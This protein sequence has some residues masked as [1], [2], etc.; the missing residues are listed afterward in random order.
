MA[1]AVLR[2]NGYMRIIS[3]RGAKGLAAE[4]TTDSIALAATLPV[5][6]I[7][8]DIHHTRN[9]IVVAYHNFATPHKLAISELTF[10]TLKRE[11]PHIATLQDA[12]RSCGKTPALIESKAPG[13]IAKSLDIIAKHPK[14]AIASFKPEE[15]LAARIHLPEHQTFL[16]QRFRPFGIIKKAQQIDASGITINKNW[17]LLL[18]YYYWQAQRHGLAIYTYTLNSAPVAKLLAK[19]MPKLYICTDYPTRLLNP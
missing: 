8:F 6:Y 14:A 3:H 2:Y 15:I 19:F 9:N 1:R 7:E 4:N 16:L 11:V 18:P 12:L 17:L 10:N 5:S 13:T